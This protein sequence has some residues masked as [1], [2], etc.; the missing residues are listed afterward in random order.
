M[1]RIAATLIATGLLVGAMVS[2]ASAERIESDTE[3]VWVEYGTRWLDT[4][5]SPQN[6]PADKKPTVRVTA[7]QTVVP[8][9]V[10]IVDGLRSAELTARFTKQNN[11]SVT[12]QKY[13]GTFWDWHVELTRPYGKLVPE[14]SY[15]TPWNDLK[16]QGPYGYDFDAVLVDIDFGDDGHQYG[17][18]RDYVEISVV[19]WCE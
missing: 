8:Y 5:I 11:P 17:T 15:I 9:K 13:S 18:P 6:C 7:G 2:P 14:Y 3:G 4:N 1:K 12:K 19:R 16:V 10:K